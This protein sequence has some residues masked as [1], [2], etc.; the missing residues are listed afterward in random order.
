M[1]NLTSFGREKSSQEMSTELMTKHESIDLQREEPLSIQIQTPSSAKKSPV[2]RWFQRLFILNERA[3]PQQ[4]R[5]IFIVMMSTIHVL[6]YFLISTDIHPRPWPFTMKL[7]HLGKFY[8][9]CMQ[10][11]SGEVRTRPISCPSWMM[12]KT[13]YYDLALQ[14]TCTPFLYPHQF[15]RFFTVNLFHLTWLH[16]LCN[17]SIQLIQGI[18]LE[19]KYGPFRLAMIY[20]LSGLGAS[21]IFIIRN[22]DVCK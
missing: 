7:F 6:V 4:H 1:L 15:W 8:L 2:F 14:H 20:W 3:D 16:L 11:A 12:K 17:L 10:A 18:P 5:P 13:C 9:P 19:R 22:Q 21:T